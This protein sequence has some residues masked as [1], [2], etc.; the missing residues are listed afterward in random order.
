[1]PTSSVQ[2]IEQVERVTQNVANWL[3]DHVNQQVIRLEAIV[4]K[5]TNLNDDRQNKSKTD[6]YH[7]VPVTQ[8][9][10]GYL[11]RHMGFHSKPLK[12]SLLVGRK[13]REN[14]RLALRDGCLKWELFSKVMLNLLLEKPS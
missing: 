7:P 8:D 9:V 13:Y 3:V 1:M 14:M 10:S 5:N 2:H 12:L 11:D 6:R 4:S